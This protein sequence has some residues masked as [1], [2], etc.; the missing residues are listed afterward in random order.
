MADHGQQAVSVPRKLWY[1]CS[2]DLCSSCNSH[3]ISKQRKRTF[4]TYTTHLHA[5]NTPTRRPLSC[6]ASCRTST[7]STVSSS[8]YLHT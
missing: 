3:S 2:V 8:R 7:A 5:G 1:V 4:M 6:T